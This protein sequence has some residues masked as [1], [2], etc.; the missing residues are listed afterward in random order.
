M[1]SSLGRGFW[2]HP[3]LRHHFFLTPFSSYIFDTS[4]SVA[5]FCSNTHQWRVYLLSIP[6]DLR[7]DCFLNKDF[8]QHSLFTI[9][10]SLYTIHTLPWNCTRKNK[11]HYETYNLTQKE[12]ERSTESLC[13]RCRWIGRIKCLSSTWY[14]KD[15][16][17]ITQTTVYDSSRQGSFFPS[18]TWNEHKVLQFAGWT[19]IYS[20]AFKFV[21]TFQHPQATCSYSTSRYCIPLTH[22]NGKAHHTT[23]RIFQSLQR[24]H[25]SVCR[26][27]T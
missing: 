21:G 10:Y 27:Y 17:A 1:L 26:D 5:F 18:W 3:S 16:H 13:W 6:F 25:C 14:Y 8:W 24:T 11:N 7:E 12:K 20:V 22:W 19:Q 2:S 15:S 23:G 4:Q 9:H